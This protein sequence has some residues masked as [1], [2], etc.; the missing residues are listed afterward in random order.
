MKLSHQIE[1][2]FWDGDNLEN[3]V[4][5]VKERDLEELEPRVGSTDSVRGIDLSKKEKLI[6][7]QLKD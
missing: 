4:E 1:D 2:R 6:L 7:N 3:L 5:E